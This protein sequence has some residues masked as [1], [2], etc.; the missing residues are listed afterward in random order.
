MGHKAETDRLIGDRRPQN[1]CEA[2]IIRVRAAHGPLLCYMVWMPWMHAR[3]NMDDL[4]TYF[5]QLR[6][7]YG[8]A[9]NVFGRAYPGHLFKQFGID[10]NDDYRIAISVY[11]MGDLN[12]SDIAHLCHAQILRA[13]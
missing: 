12:S 4:S 6:K 13:A 10:D 8:L 3:I 5:F 7:K 1:S 11:I 2:R 9:Q